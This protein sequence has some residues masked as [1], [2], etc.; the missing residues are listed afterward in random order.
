MKEDTKWNSANFVLF[1]TTVIA[2][3]HSSCGQKK[4]EIPTQFHIAR[5][6]SWGV[7]DYL[8]NVSLIFTGLTLFFSVFRLMYAN[9]SSLTVSL[10]IT[11][12]QVCQRLC[13]YCRL[14]SRTKHTL[15]P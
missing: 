6:P 9:N 10:V 2:A 5:E 13:F 14:I 8:T 3:V 15:L 11:S 12:W 4:K 1:N 7:S